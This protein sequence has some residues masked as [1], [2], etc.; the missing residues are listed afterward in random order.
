MNLLT[1]GFAA[2][3]GIT[4]ILLIR[5]LFRQA[6]IEDAIKET[7]DLAQGQMRL[8]EEFGQHLD[9]GVGIVDEKGLFVYVNQTFADLTGQPNRSAVGQSVDQVM[10]LQDAAA[11]AADVPTGN[12]SKQLYVISKDGRRTPVRAV[13]R[14]LK[15]PDGYGVVI[16]K[17]A[18]AE[19]AE[20]EIR[21]RLVKLSSF[22]LRAPI[23]AMKGYASMLLDGDA[24]KLPKDAE[25]YVAP[26]VESA[27]KVLT[28]IDDMANVEA[29]SAKKAPAKLAPIDTTD[30]LRAIHERLAKVTADADRKFHLGEGLA[31]ATITID[32]E[33]VARLLSM[34]VNTAARTAAQGS[35]VVLTVTHG[36]GTANFEI[37]N[38][39]S[40][41]PKESQAN[42][43]DYVGGAGLD[44]GIGFY[45]AKQ[46][47]EE[48]QAFVT[49]NTRP[50][51]NVFILSIPAVEAKTP[52][53]SEAAAALDAAGS[54]KKTAPSTPSPQAEEKIPLESR[55][56]PKPKHPP[57]SASGKR[58]TGDLKRR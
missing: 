9:E 8:W 28:I 56:E 30:F 11:Q 31:H 33:H 49:V 57:A 47:I 40:P 26:I 7:S 10:N 48:H 38:Q 34:L 29:L 41:L 55:P 14:A 25:A 24:G 58:M 46:I 39:G 52:D 20:K 50:E 22:E 17:N 27:N 35:E 19:N 37:T 3:F 36:P 44:E 51:G 6:G 5:S 21:Q 16:L 4:L 2:A 12:V 53:V 23:T 15:R 32:R 42:V 45:V 1:I 43:F 54:P 13:R 18:T